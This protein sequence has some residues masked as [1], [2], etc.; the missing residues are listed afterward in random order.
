MKER[1]MKSG[2]LFEKE[3]IF[4]IISQGIGVFM[5]TIVTFFIGLN[6]WNQ[7]TGQTM[8]FCV[9]AF[10]QMLRAFSYQCNSSLVFSKNRTRNKYVGISIVVSALLIS[11]SILDRKS[12]RL[13]SSHKRSSRMP[14]SA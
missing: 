12:T 5:V 4:N 14:S 13:N 3:T 7:T 2:K 8:A 9:L 1:P 10:S 6:Y 11:S